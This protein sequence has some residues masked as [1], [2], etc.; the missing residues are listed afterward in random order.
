M[1]ESLSPRLSPTTSGPYHQPLYINADAEQ[2]FKFTKVDLRKTESLG[3]GSH[4]AVGKKVPDSLIPRQSLTQ[5]LPG[6][7]SQYHMPLYV[8]TAASDQQ[9]FKFTR[10]ELRKTETLGS[11][12][13]GAVCI[14]KCDELL[15]AAKLLFTVLFDMDEGPVSPR[16]SPRINRP[17]RIPLRRF[18]QE[19]RF[20]S[21]IKHPNI[22]QY[23]GTYRDPDSRALVLLMELMDESLTHFLVRMSVP[24]P[25][26]LEVGISHDVAVALAYL[27]S[28]NIIHRDLSGNNVLLIHGCR[29]KVSDFGMSTLVTNPSGNSRTV[30]PG[31]PVYMPPEALNETPKYS[32]MLDSFSFGVVVLQILTREFPNPTDRFTAMKVPHPQQ[33]N[34]MTEAKFDVPEK[35]R[36]KEHIDMVRQDEPLLDIVLDC[37]ND[38]DSGRPSA[39]TLCSR[40]EALK[41]SH[42]YVESHADR[43][44]LEIVE[45]RI[46]AARQDCEQQHQEQ[47]EE[48]REQ[49]ENLMQEVQS[50]DDL[51]KIRVDHLNS[52]KKDL[53]AKEGECESL[54]LSLR[55]DVELQEKERALEGV[56]EHKSQQVQRMQQQVDLQDQTVHDLHSVIHRHEQSIAELRTQLSRE[57]ERNSLLLQKLSRA[58]Q[59]E[60]TVDLDEEEGDFEHPGMF[61]ALRQQHDAAKK[62]KEITELKKDLESKETY[63]Q[64]L[65]R[66]LQLLRENSQIVRDNQ[67][68]LM[69]QRGPKAPSKMF[70]VSASSIGSKAYFRPNGS[71]EIYEFCVDSNEWNQ[72]LSC[73]T[74]SSTLVT[75]DNMLT[76]VGG[77]NPAQCL[78]LQSSKW[79]SVYPH[80][81]Y[82]RYNSTAIKCGGY[83]VVAGG[84]SEN[85]RFMPTVEILRLSTKQWIPCASLPFSFH[86]ASGVAINDTL[87]LLGGFNKRDGSLRSVLSCSL[88]YLVGSSVSSSGPARPT[89]AVWQRLADLPF[90]GA[91]CVSAQGHL[92]AIGGQDRH[93]KV[94]STIYTY[95]SSQNLWELLTHL[96]AARSDCLVSVI[97]TNSSSKL[98]IVGGYTENGLSESVEIASVSA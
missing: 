77:A 61:I 12:S 79:I 91:T 6:P 27:H 16:L 19:C 10:I 57:S 92:F 5:N 84:I 58:E 23:L 3:S 14:A 54:R 44:D 67:I 63:I 75:I 81:Q 50:K 48:M 18:E 62:D 95:N 37:L 29:A 11:G 46:T 7:G 13:Y 90:S 71:S 25:Y 56:I 31:T 20:L 87:Y 64:A 72:L 82:G 53:S 41:A 86:S 80:M 93:N 33:P 78:S 38:R 73:T 65:E 51:L 68:N 83:L 94:Q 59:S 26:H 35:V 4:R 21:Q 30:C 47:L 66:Q 15:C 22:V 89:T 52:L 28:N 17:H 24:I 36:R 60:H 1:S 8:N 40:L 32:E 9:E 97:T 96:K 2:E 76:I 98:V 34:V 55:D 45:R 49:M 88:K 39:S 70:G 42:R 74:K 85:G 69:L 43:L